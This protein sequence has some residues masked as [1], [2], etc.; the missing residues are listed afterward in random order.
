VHF[1]KETDKLSKIS[2]LIPTSPVARKTASTYRNE[3]IVLHL[4]T[5]G[6]GIELK[7]PTY[8]FMS[9]IQ[10]ICLEKIICDFR[11]RADLVATAAASINAGLYRSKVL[12]S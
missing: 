1:N 8:N 12:R 11:K 10:E 9:L 2:H 7:G 3:L 5:E 4:H 6:I